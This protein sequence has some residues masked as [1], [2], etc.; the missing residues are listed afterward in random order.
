V[1]LAPEEVVR[2]SFGRDVALDVRKIAESYWSP[3][4]VYHEDPQWPG[5][6]SFYGRE[7]VARRVEEYFESMEVL[8]FDLVEVVEAEDSLFWTVRLAARG[9]GSGAPMEHCWGYVGRVEDGRIAEIRA[10]VDPDAARA[11]AG[12][13]AA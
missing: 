13:D 2:A 12:L 11:A 8:A 5:A 10:F 7:A 4:V 9:A 3:D 6:G 1:T